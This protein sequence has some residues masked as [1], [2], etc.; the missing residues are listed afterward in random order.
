VMITD[1][2]GNNKIDLKK[3]PS[4]LSASR[5]SNFASVSTPSIFLGMSFCVCPSFASLRP[6]FS[7]F[8]FSPECRMPQKVPRRPPSSFHQAAICRRGAGHGKSVFL[9]LSLC[10]RLCLCL[11]FRVF[12]LPPF[13]Q[14]LSAPFSPHRQCDK[15]DSIGQCMRRPACPHALILIALALKQTLYPCGLPALMCCA[16]FRC[17]R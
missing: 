15:T 7:L 9:S 2:T 8:L 11:C 5:P 1:L 12:I 13:Y 16:V 17:D 6:T 14:F 10:L 3:V 4:P